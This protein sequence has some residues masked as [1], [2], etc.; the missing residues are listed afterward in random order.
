MSAGLENRSSRL[1]AAKAPFK[2]VCFWLWILLPLNR[3]QEIVFLAFTGHPARATHAYTVGLDAVP[4]RLLDTRASKLPDYRV[5]ARMSDFVNRLSLYQE[6][7]LRASL[8]C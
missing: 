7:R 1:I 5:E 6:H 3:T 2:A 4:A 8:T